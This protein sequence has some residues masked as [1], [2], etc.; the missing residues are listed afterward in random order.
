[1]IM[2]KILI[3]SLLV[4]LASCT[5]D[6]DNPSEEN[7][8]IESIHYTLDG[9]TLTVD[10]EVVENDELIVVENDNS[11]LINNFLLENEN[12]IEYVLDDANIILFRNDLALQ[13]Y[14]QEIGSPLR[15][16]KNE[17]ATSARSFPYT[18]F[19]L[20]LYWDCCYDTRKEFFWDFD[21]DISPICTVLYNNE[22]RLKNFANVDAWTLV[23]GSVTF[24]CYVSS[25]NKPNDRLESVLARNV[26]ARFY[27]HANYGGSSIV[28][29]ARNGEVRGFRKLRQVRNG[30]FGKNWRDRISSVKL[31]N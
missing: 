16:T 10:F 9:K 14:L 19:N 4:L 2:K 26:F 18:S 6:G 31:S 27:E 1:M 7:P 17:S 11:L 15:S 30:L 28:L 5:S 21:N 24:G 29:D 20:E 13:A 8:N 12:H 22:S 23:T 25:N 3:A